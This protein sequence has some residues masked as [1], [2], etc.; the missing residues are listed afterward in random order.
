MK[1]NKHPW[2]SNVRFFNHGITKGRLS[3][4]FCPNRISNAHPTPWFQDLCL[5]VLL[6]KEKH[7]LKKCN[8]LYLTRCANEMKKNMPF[9]TKIWNQFQPKP[10]PVCFSTFILL[11]CSE[12]MFNLLII[13]VAKIKNTNGYTLLEIDFLFLGGKYP[14]KWLGVPTATPR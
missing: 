7:H 6:V 12:S 10:W 4:L 2:H 8:C 11:A 9:L 1:N 3:L 5:E 14:P 13:F